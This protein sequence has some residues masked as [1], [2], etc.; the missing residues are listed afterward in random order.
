[1]LQQERDDDDNED[2]EMHQNLQEEDDILNLIQGPLCS[3][4][5]CGPHTLQLA[6]KDVTKDYIEV[7]DQVRAVVIRSKK[8][9]YKQVLANNRVKKLRS[10]V[11]SR[12]D[13]TY[14]ML[15]DVHR[16]RQ[17]LETVA[18]TYPVL[19]ISDE[20]WDFIDE[21]VQSFEP[22]HQAMLEF[23]RADITM[24]DFYLRWARMQA[25]IGTL[26]N[27][28][29]NLATKLH[30]SKGLKIT[31]LTSYQPYFSDK[32]IKSYEFLNDINTYA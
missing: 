6:A 9:M 31:F 15:S 20:C 28:P 2:D 12:W 16:N 3:K 7:I 21:Y 32:P 25:K 24:S 4:M 27:G 13:S 17:G 8:M 29:K 1:M 19:A 14:L 11:K 18:E 22:V 10:D 26:E 5:V 30:D 23:Q